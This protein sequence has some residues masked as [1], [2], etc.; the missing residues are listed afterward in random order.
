MIKAF[1]K[2]NDNNNRHLSSQL[3]SHRDLRIEF[4]VERGKKSFIDDES[5]KEII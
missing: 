4:C 2:W 3:S 1:K 5:E